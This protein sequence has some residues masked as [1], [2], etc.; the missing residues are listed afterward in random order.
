MANNFDRMWAQA[1]KKVLEIVAD[2]SQWDLFV[3]QVDQHGVY[4]NEHKNARERARKSKD[5]RAFLEGLYIFYSATQICDACDYS[6]NHRKG[7][8]K[9]SPRRRFDC[10]WEK[11]KGDVLAEQTARDEGHGGASYKFNN[12]EWKAKYEELSQVVLEE[13]K[14]R[15]KAP[16][17][18][19]T[20]K[21]LCQHYYIDLTGP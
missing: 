17:W 10:T 15:T 8:R 14:D 2:D 13:H 3:Q 21:N 1:R 7:Q 9:F 4:L 6:P 20:Q 12:P 16:A 5:Y 18:L 19:D 11:T